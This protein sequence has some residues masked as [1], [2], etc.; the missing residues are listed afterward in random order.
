M[1]DT[2][3]EL[4]ARAARGASPVGRARVS[5]AI[6]PQ[7]TNSR[8]LEWAAVGT[9]L[10]GHYPKDTLV[11]TVPLVAIGYHSNVPILDLVGLTEPAI[12]RA[13]RSVPEGSLTRNWIGHERNNT[14]YVL[15][16]AQSRSRAVPRGRRGSVASRSHPNVRAE[17]T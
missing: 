16:R 12:A 10:R 5:H 9:Y 3:M 1:F 2:Y 4:D 8:V 7:H 17:L 6:P 13:R 15:E 14:E 11:A